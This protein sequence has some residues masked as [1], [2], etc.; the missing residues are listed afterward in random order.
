[1]L[2]MHPPVLIAELPPGARFVQKPY[3]PATLLREIDGI[4]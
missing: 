2:R 3:R 1:M 4:G